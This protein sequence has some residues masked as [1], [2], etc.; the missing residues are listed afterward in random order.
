M[1]PYLVPFEGVGKFSLNKSIQV[2]L[3]NFHFEIEDFSKDKYAPSIHYIL[4]HPDITLFV[5]NDIINSIS[6]YEELIYKGRN[7]INLTLDQFIS[8]TEEY[9]TEVDELNFDDDD[10]PQY[11]YEFE[12]LGLQVW[13]KGKDGRIVTII[14]NSYEH[15]QD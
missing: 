3:E 12:N 1:I 6:C 15:Y 9:Y 5:E 4:S 13:E 14:V 8:I 10:I 7:L 2:Y 11:V